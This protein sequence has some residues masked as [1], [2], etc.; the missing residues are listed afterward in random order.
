MIP[1]HLKQGRQ[2]WTTIRAQVR[3]AAPVNAGAAS[4][5]A[6]LLD[7]PDGSEKDFHPVT[8]RLAAV[9]VDWGQLVGLLH[10]FGICKL[11]RM[12]LRQHDVGLQPEART[13]RPGVGRFGPL[14]TEG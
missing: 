5:Q 9:P 12:L 6:V 3:M 10:G 14:G 1:C 4:L 8:C 11:N 2:T 7:A 13:L